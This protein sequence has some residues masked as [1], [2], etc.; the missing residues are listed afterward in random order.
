MRDKKKKLK[1]LKDN[2]L[3]EDADF[4]KKYQKALEEETIN[5]IEKNKIIKR[6]ESNLKSLGI[7]IIPVVA[8]FLSTQ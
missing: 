8:F 5:V 1:K 3:I 7:K 4:E 6:L 2:D